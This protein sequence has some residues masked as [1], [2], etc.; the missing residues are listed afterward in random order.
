MSRS[1]SLEKALLNG[2]PHIGTSPPPVLFTGRVWHETTAVGTPVESWIW[3]G[4][5]WI[6]LNTYE[7][8]FPSSSSNT[9][10]ATL[11]N[12]LFPIDPASNILLLNFILSG[13]QSSTSSGSNL[14][15]FAIDR[16]TSQSYT[17]IS[18]HNTNSPSPWAGNVWTTVSYPINIL[19]NIGGAL[20][21]KFIRVNE[22]RIGTSTKIFSYIIKYKKVRP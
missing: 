20:T 14:W 13:I 9:N 15:S 2:V 11:N 1:T 7:F 6:S 21:T 5:N 4:T 10:N 17:N 18:T 12:P 19:V 8:L 22:S 16:L 3:N